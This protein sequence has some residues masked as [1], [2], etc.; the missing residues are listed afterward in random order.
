MPMISTD[1]KQKTLTR[2]LSAVLTDKQHHPSAYLDPDLL[3]H[4]SGSLGMKMSIT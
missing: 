2:N 4:Y 1:S 3:Q